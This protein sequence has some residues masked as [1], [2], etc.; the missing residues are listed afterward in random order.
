M[1]KK[2]CPLILLLVAVML[3]TTVAVSAAAETSQYPKVTIQVSFGNNAQ[4]A[5]GLG[6]YEWKRLV[7]E[8]NVNVTVEV[9]P[10][11]QLGANADL[12]EQILMGEPMVLLTDGS[13][14]CEYGAPELG[15]LSMPY[16]FDNWDQCWNVLESDWWNEQSNL[17]KEKGIHVICGNWIAG[18]RQIVCN[19]E[20]RS[21]E[22]MKGLKLRV[23]NNALSVAYFTALGVAAT[24]MSLSDTYTSIQQGLIDGQENPLQ[25]CYTAGYY[26]ICDYLILSSHVNLPAQFV[27]SE[28]FWNSLDPKQQEVITDCAIQGG[29]F[30]NEEYLRVEQG[31]LDKFKEEGTTIC[32][33]DEATLATFKEAVAPAFEDPAVSAN[34]R[35]GLREMIL[36]LAATDRNKK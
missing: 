27:C 2:N 7:E 26:E 12:M 10:S 20:I 6:A 35:P 5:Q 34:W 3:M 22:N 4:D 19:R 30:C 32:E 9:F 14:L 23:P 28:T 18:T 16:L 25:Y 36:E 31:Y 15:V 8:Q 33:L 1:S 13:F 24:P 11:N 21:L 17:L 29:W